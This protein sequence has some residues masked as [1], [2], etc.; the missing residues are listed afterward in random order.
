MTLSE[1]SRGGAA[2]TA[3]PS[4]TTLCSRRRNSTKQACEEAIIRTRKAALSFGNSV[5]RK[6]GRHFPVDGR[7]GSL[8]DDV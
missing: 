1:T 3:D 5:R 2:E 6:A 8:T 4:V 7:S